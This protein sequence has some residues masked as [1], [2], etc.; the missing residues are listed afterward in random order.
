MFMLVQRLKIKILPILLLAPCLLV[1]QLALTTNLDGAPSVQVDIRHL[2]LPMPTSEKRSKYGNN[3][4]YEV[5]G[6]TYRVSPTAIGYRQ[7]GIASWYGKKFH[8]RRTSSGDA[9]NMYKFTAAHRSLPLPSWVKVVN[10]ENGIWLYVRVN[11][12]GP[13]HE[14]R[15][16]DLSYASAA[17]L[18]MLDKGTA[19]VAVEYMAATKPPTELNRFMLQVGAFL[20][21]TK[22]NELATHLNGLIKSKVSIEPVVQAT[23]TIFR[24]HVGP[25]RN[26]QEARDIRH[27]IASILG[28]VDMLVVEKPA[29]EYYK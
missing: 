13:F 27:F 28:N 20:N 9:Y 11:D 4:S 12:R 2:L 17:Y 29:F 7:V 6:R 8:G 22:A 10:L 24:V 14:E 3:A 5:F 21:G 25:F 18:D 26:I 23:R 19:N 1:S 16:I 15:I